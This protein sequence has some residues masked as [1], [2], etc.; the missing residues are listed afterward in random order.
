MIPVLVV[1]ERVH[2]PRLSAEQV[3]RWADL[4]RR[5]P[6]DCVL[7]TPALRRGATRS[8]LEQ[9]LGRPAPLCVNLLPPDRVPGS[10][11]VAQSRA[12]ASELLEARREGRLLVD[13]VVL[14]G[15][16][17]AAAFGA[18]WSWRLYSDFHWPDPTEPQE[19]QGL[20]V[21]VLPHPSGRSRLLNVP[22]VRGAVARAAAI[23]LG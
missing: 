7:R 2:E 5:R 1:G 12:V 19:I 13:R 15:C 18:T 9:M 17:V 8:R 20:R 3:E 10:W 4:W 6:L 11:E 23:F 21:L 22:H 14:L 16:R